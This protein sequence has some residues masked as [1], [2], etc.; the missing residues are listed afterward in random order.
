[1]DINGRE[2]ELVTPRG[3][4]G[5]AATNYLV[6]HVS[7]Q[8][9]EKSVDGLLVLTEEKEFLDVHLPQFFEKEDAKWVD[10]NATTGE[11]L[12][13]IMAVVEEVFEGF[14]QPDVEAATKNSPEAQEGEEG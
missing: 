7:A 12:S 3:R 10:E 9:E 14:N 13:L 4:K 2:V 8:D 11:L 5:R 1:M 6:K